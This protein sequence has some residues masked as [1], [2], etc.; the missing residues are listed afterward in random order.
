MN[1]W[2]VMDGNGLSHVVFADKI[3][4]NPSYLVFMDGEDEVVAVFCNWSHVE[5]APSSRD[6][7][8]VA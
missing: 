8:K 5:K 2:R 7:L 6:K 1:E 3:D 4:F